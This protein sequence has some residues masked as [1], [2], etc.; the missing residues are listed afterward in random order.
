MNF[1]VVIWPQLD[2][3]QLAR[4]VIPDDGAGSNRFIWRCRACEPALTTGNKLQ[5]DRCSVLVTIAWRQFNL[6]L[7]LKHLF[8]HTGHNQLNGAN[9]VSHRVD[10]EHATSHHLGLRVRKG[11]EHQAGTI[12]QTK[13]LVQIQRLEVLGLTGTVGDTDSFDATEHV[14]HGGLTDIGETDRSHHK[15]LFVCLTT[16]QVLRIVLEEGE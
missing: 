16:C 15:S 13:I 1:F 5:E 14:D 7:A 6:V 4:S 2:V 8:R 12:A 9:I 10:V 3:E 11:G